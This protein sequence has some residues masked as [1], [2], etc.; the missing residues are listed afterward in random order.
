MYHSKR[1]ATFHVNEMFGVD[2]HYNTYRNMMRNTM[3]YGHYKGVDNYTTGYV[4]K[5]RWENWQRIN[6]KNIWN[7]KTASNNTYIFTQLLICACCG[8]RLAGSTTVTKG[9]QYFYYRCN[10]A[11]MSGQCNR[12]YIINQEKIEKYLLE[13]IKREIEEYIHQYEVQHAQP[14]QR[15][16]VDRVKKL[17]QE[18]ERVNY[19][20]RKNRIS[21]AEYDEQYEELVK[22]IS[23]A[24]AEEQAAAKPPEPKDLDA[25]REF[26]KFDLQGL[27]PDLTAE[28]KRALWRSIISRIVVSDDGDLAVKF[29]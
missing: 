11:K 17:E 25:L 7:R 3:M 22:R 24:R 27:Y 2:Y 6:E 29:L 1:K 5:E 21:M 12:R 18:L 23:E 16:K 28:E 26:L 14:V 20:F 19:Q 9:K 15:P 13:N 8:T 10:K 4:T